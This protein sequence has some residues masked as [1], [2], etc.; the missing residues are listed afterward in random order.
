MRS[1]RD[2]DRYILDLAAGQHGVVHLRQLQ[3]RNITGPMITRRVRGGLLTRLFAGTYVVGPEHGELSLATRCMAAVLHCGPGSRV[4]GTTAARL[5]GAWDRGRADVHVSVQRN[6]RSPGPQGTFFHRTGHGSEVGRTSVVSGI[7]VAGFLDMC[8]RAAQ[9]LTKWQ[10]AAVIREGVYLELVTL[11][12]LICASELRAGAPGNATLRDAIQLVARGS[13]GTRG[14]TEDA[15]LD[16]LLRLGA[17]EPIVNTR[18]S[19]GMHRDEPDFVWSDRRFNLE[20]DGPHHDDPRQAADDA[21]RDAEAFDRGWTVVR[22][23]T[24][25]YWRERRGAI[26]RIMQQLHR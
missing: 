20:L 4:D 22:L 9:Q 26:R 16:D 18:G 1:A 7:P 5:V 3:V 23:R 19:M 2:I 10:L 6:V 14:V 8:A 21:L 12:D 24:R 13:A 25:D 17:D 11:T 15:V